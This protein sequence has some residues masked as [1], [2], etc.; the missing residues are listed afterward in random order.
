MPDREKGRGQYR[1]PSSQPVDEGIE[2]AI[3]D[4]DDNDRGDLESDVR[5]LH[6]A[7]RGETRIASRSSEG[8]EAE[9]ARGDQQKI[10]NDAGEESPPDT[11]Q[12]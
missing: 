12:S 3:F 7:A 6:A 10:E 11:R 1:G 9:K 2:G 8:Q 4:D 5:D